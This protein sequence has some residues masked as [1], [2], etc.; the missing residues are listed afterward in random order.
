MSDQNPLAQLPGPYARTASPLLLLPREILLMIL[1]YLGIDS[2]AAAVWRSLEQATRL[3]Y[4][5]FR[6]PGYFRAPY[7]AA[8]RLWVLNAPPRAL[9]APRP[10]QLPHADTSTTNS[11]M[12]ALSAADAEFDRLE[13]MKKR[14]AKL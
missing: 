2:E 14:K 13:R 1:S 3:F 5:L 8:R 12:A 6:A 9:S 10:R 7:L 4:N 11:I